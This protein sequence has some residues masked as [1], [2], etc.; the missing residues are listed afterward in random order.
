[1]VDDLL[2]THDLRG[3]GRSQVVSLLGEPDQTNWDTDGQLVYHLGPER[4]LFR[5]DSEWL[6]VT[7]GDDGK[8]TKYVLARD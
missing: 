8:V 7:V 1:M 2:R 6:V 4:G 5:I 3:W